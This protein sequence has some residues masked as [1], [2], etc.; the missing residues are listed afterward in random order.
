MYVKSYEVK[1]NSPRL[2][3]K[4]RDQIHDT[5]SSR[6]LHAS[7]AGIGERHIL[8]DMI[9]K[10]QDMLLISVY[11]WC[12]ESHSERA[13]L[14][15]P[16]PKNRDQIYDTA[17]SRELHASTEGIG[18][19]HILVDMIEKSQDMLLISVFV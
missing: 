3:P 16:T 11:V 4:N 7:T 6:E 13:D 2:T 19:Q 8:I 17:S 1:A 18:E 10:S 15:R 14:P 9:E 12:V 5:T